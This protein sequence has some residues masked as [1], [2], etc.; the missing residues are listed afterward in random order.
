MDMEFKI[1]HEFDSILND[2]YVIF[3][4]KYVFEKIQNL[5]HNDTISRIIKNITHCYNKT[6]FCYRQSI[7]IKTNFEQSV[8]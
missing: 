5:K 1:H 4:A 7:D 2:Y 3:A 6:Y 8:K